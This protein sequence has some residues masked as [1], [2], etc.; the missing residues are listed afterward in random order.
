VTEHLRNGVHFGSGVEQLDVPVAECA[1][2]VGKAGGSDVVV[3]LGRELG[4][5]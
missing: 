1:D 4:K 5:G 2:V 3:P